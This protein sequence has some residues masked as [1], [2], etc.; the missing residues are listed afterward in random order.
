MVST[1]DWIKW[2]G[3]RAYVG[4]YQSI[5]RRVGLVRT[6]P[7][8]CNFGIYSG[9]IALLVPKTPIRVPGNFVVYVLLPQS[10]LHVQG[11]HVQPSGKSCLGSHS[12]LHTPTHRGGYPLSQSGRSTGSQNRHVLTE[13]KVTYVLHLW[14][15]DI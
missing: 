9:S 11:Y 7:S 4:G 5:H 8:G 2:N 13:Y 15:T 14:K 3:S 10:V 6:W 12:F 1:R